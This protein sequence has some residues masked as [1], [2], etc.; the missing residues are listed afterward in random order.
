MRRSAAGMTASLCDFTDVRCA[1]E[2]S[3][4]LLR[5]NHSSP[6]G[7]ARDWRAERACDARA[8]RRRGRAAAANPCGRRRSGIGA[9]L[10]PLTGLMPRSAHQFAA[11]VVS[12]EVGGR[13]T[14]SS[15]SGLQA[16][17]S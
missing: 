1:A 16:Q 14:D 13:H 6:G 3:M 10:A 7:G 2:N 11:C 8:E 9:H 4:V 12:P 17:A 5:Q 15:C